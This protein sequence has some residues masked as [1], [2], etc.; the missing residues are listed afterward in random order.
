M[1]EDSN[2]LYGTTAA[3]DDDVGTVEHGQNQNNPT[4]LAK[5][6]DR[7][8]TSRWGASCGHQWKTSSQRAPMARAVRPAP[9]PSGEQ[10]DARSG[11]AG[12]EL[13]AG[14]PDH[15]PLLM[16]HVLDSSLRPTP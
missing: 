5:A 10:H 4:W 9:G 3:A 6:R 14:R 16:R 12:F 7:W 8:N 2:V 1:A 13:R 15:A 11:I